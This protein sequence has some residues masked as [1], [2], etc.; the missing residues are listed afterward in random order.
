M[1]AAIRIP[2]AIKARQWEAAGDV[3]YTVARMVCKECDRL[4]VQAEVATGFGSI[5]SECPE[6]GARAAQGAEV[7]WTY[8]PAGTLIVWSE[9][10]GRFPRN[11]TL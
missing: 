9:M 5:T 3:S 11:R 8:A 2:D 6:C 4:W 10:P 1:K 7:V